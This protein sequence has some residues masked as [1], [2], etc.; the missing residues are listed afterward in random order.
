MSLG[1]KSL[2]QKP[3]RRERNLAAVK[4]AKKTKKRRTRQKAKR[5]TREKV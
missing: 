1:G 4:V 5:K 2:P 3:K